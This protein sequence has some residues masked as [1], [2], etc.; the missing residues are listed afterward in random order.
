MCNLEIHM[1]MENHVLLIL[2]NQSVMIV[3]VWLEM[4]CKYCCTKL[5]FV[6]KIYYFYLFLLGYKTSK[7]DRRFPTITKIIFSFGTRLH[8][9][10]HSQ[11]K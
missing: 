8:F 2:H 4:S 9:F 11:L 1:G 7:V 10:V 5:G 3:P 6:I